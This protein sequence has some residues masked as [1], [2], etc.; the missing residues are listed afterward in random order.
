MK[1]QNQSH[2]LCAYALPFLY[3]NFFCSFPWIY[4]KYKLYSAHYYN[5]FNKVGSC[6][7]TVGDWQLAVVG[8]QWRLAV[9]SSIPQILKSPNL[10]HP[11]SGKGLTY[12]ACNKRH[13]HIPS[14]NLPKF[15]VGQLFLNWGRLQKPV[16]H[17]RQ[18]SWPCS[19]L[20]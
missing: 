18:R 3:L 16:G 15:S 12:G 7:L 11:A 4:G 1:N 20:A 2:K 6:R 17:W 8:C 13:C 14:G 5:S 10:Q 9:D 19:P